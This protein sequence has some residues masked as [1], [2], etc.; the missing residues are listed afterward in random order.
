MNYRYVERDDD[1]STDTVD[2]ALRWRP[3]DW[4]LSLY[5]E[6]RYIS[7][8]RDDIDLRVGIRNPG[9]GASVAYRGLEHWSFLISRYEYSYSTDLDRLATQ[10]L[11]V[12]FL[13]T[14]LGEE[15]DESRT[16]L[17]IDYAFSRLTLGVTRVRSIAALDQSVTIAWDV[18]ASWDITDRV[19]LFGYYGRSR[20]EDVDNADVAGGGVSVYWD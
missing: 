1:L 19:G 15:F 2:G 10:S 6:V 18:S 3:R 7:L 14:R 8:G 5:P 16:A 4:T 9:L 13:S 12:R 17:A 11:L 20:T